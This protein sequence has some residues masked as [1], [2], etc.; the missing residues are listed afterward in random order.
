V[1]GHR[2]DLTFQ[3]PAVNQVQYPESVRMQTEEQPIVFTNSLTVLNTLMY[4]A[5]KGRIRRKS[6]IAVNWMAART[7][8][9]N[10][11]VASAPG[12]ALY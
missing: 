10:R 6:T 9:K 2:L 8:R 11:S 1:L 12:L 7:N 5:P 3:A 4:C